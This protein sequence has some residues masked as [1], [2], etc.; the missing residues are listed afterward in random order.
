MTLVDVFQFIVHFTI[1]HPSIVIGCIFGI[2]KILS[3]FVGKKKKHN[4]ESVQ[5]FSCVFFF[6]K[7]N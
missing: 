7:H 3:Y 1:S 5:T 4:R 2:I 6:E